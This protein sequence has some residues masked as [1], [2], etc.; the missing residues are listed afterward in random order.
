MSN[1]SK[2]FLGNSQLKVSSICLGG[3]PLGGGMGA[4]DRQQAIR[5]VHAAIDNGINFIDTA[6][7]YRT[8]EEIIGEALLGCRDRVILATKLSGEH[9]PEH[10]RTAIDKSLKN[11]QTDYIDLYQIHYPSTTWPIVDTMAE[12]L[13]LQDEGKIRSI[14]VSNFSVEQIAEAACYGE[15]TSVQPQYSMLFREIEQDLLPYCLSEGIGTMVYGPIA[16]GLLSGNYLASHVF[17]DDDDRATHRSLTEAVREAAVEICARLESWARDHGH[18]MVQ[19]AIAWTLAHPAV[20][21]AI[22]GAKSPTQVVENCEA[23][24]WHLSS[25]E[26]AE[27]NSLIEGLSL[28]K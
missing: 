28:G 17:S 25:A 14:G 19:L 27:V 3:W 7:G 18:T 15:I 26:L 21:T 2:Q 4:I 10:I 11:L 6:E 24:R 20:T 16:R 13:K 12:L 5:V 1:L 22:S 8:S 9:S 23:G